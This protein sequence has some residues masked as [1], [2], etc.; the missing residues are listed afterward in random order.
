[1]P[2]GDPRGPSGISLPVDQAR[3]GAVRHALHSFTVRTMCTAVNGVPGF[4][5]MPDH[6]ASAVGA[7]GR[8]G[9]DRALKGIESVPLSPNVHFESF[10]VFISADFTTSHNFPCVE[11]AITPS[12]SK[13]KRSSASSRNK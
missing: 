3:T 6:F 10:V 4:D 8:Q 11:V 9:V 13:L 7:T 2:P 1:M 12:T 5:P